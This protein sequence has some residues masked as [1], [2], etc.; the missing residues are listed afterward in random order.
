[1][2]LVHRY[3]ARRKQRSPSLLSSISARGQ[4]GQRCQH[5]GWGGGKGQKSCRE[6][7]RTHRPGL[8]TR[9]QAM[10]RRRST[11]T[12]SRGCCPTWEWCPANA[13]QPT[14]SRVRARGREGKS[15]R[16]REGKRERGREGKGVVSCSKRH[17]VHIHSHTILALDR[18]NAR[19]CIIT[20]VDQL[21][22]PPLCKGLLC[23]HM[24]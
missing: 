3:P 21:F 17:L 24:V 14:P 16:A 20:A 22:G 10:P 7:S 19:G 4:R 12:R 11:R 5:A 18:P 8:R 6:G 1:M 23:S 15:A 2:S 9:S 13:R